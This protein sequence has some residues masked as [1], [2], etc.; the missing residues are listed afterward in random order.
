MLLAQ[1]PLQFEQAIE[2]RKPSILPEYIMELH[3]DQQE[4]LG[5]RLKICPDGNKLLKSIRLFKCVSIKNFDQ[6]LACYI[7]HPS[8]P[9]TLCFISIRS[10]L[11]YI[12]R[13]VSLTNTLYFISI[14]MCPVYIHKYIGL[15]K[16]LVSFLLEFHL[17]ISA[18]ILANEFHIVSFLLQFV[19]GISKYI[20]S[21][22]THFLSFPR[23][24]AWFG[25]IGFHGISTILSN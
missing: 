10:F 16:H 25:F 17:D 5:S 1:T 4:C 6:L 22:Q 13:H 8:L 3:R 14:A 9:C 11:E 18:E 15:T 24:L 20:L 19:L 7:V 12:Q 2:Q 23:N 21:F